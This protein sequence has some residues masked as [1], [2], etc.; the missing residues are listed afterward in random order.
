MAENQ[1]SGQEPNG[2]SQDIDYKAKYEEAIAHSREWEK[3]AKANK[4]AA[5][6]LEQLKQSQMSDA[7]KAAAKTAKLQ[8]ELEELKAEKQSNAWRSQVAS[9]TG[10]PANLIT[11]STLEE[12]QANAKSISEYVAAQTGRKLPEVKNPGKQPDVAPN[13]LLQFASNVF[14]N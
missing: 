1:Q 9:E 3:R 5:D 8:K 10:L 13:D 12:M 7:E 14:F 11:G 4:T 2:E 6:E